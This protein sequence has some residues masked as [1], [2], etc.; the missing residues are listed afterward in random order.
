MLRS[1]EPV[2]LLIAAARRSLRYAVQERVT[3]LRLNPPQF[4]TLLTVAEEPGVSLGELA[5]RQRIDAPA[6]SRTV[7]S[8]A[9]RGLVRLELDPGDRRRSRLSL[10]RRGDD[11]LRKLRP[12]AD[13]LR[14]RVVWGMDPSEQTAL[15]NSLRK[16]IGNLEDARVTR[17]EPARDDPARLLRAA[18]RGR[19]R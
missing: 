13:D 4:W 8:L 1:Q 17:L 6:A 15:R 18:Q 7:G 5:R 3:R 10:T 16:V 11:L 19:R 9:R 12:I 2:G 14:A